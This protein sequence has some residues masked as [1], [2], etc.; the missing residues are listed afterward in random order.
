MR[1]ELQEI[2]KRFGGTLALDGVSLDVPAGSIVAVL[3][4]NG[5]GKSTLLRLLGAVCV[6]D[7]GRICLD[8][9]P[10]DRENLT[11]RHRLMTIPDTPLLFFDK[12]VA[13]NIA[14]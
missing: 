2:T 8:G 7:E 9:E 5:A 13:R 6:A 3:G 14:M 4:E 1:V 12:S 10:F 11:L